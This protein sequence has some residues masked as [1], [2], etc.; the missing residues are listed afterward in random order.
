MYI[1]GLASPS[2]LVKQPERSGYR[3]QTGGNSGHDG[4]AAPAAA[5]IVYQWSHTA[6]FGRVCDAVR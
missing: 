3:L 5:K 1:A 2:F 6:S 4:G